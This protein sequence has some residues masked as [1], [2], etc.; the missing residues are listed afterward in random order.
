LA[1]LAS[2]PLLA[3]TVR[4]FALPLLVSPHIQRVGRTGDL[5]LLAVW[6]FR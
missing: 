3:W 5:A 1:P 4:P 2:S 6:P